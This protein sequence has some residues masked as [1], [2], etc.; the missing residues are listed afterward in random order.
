MVSSTSRWLSRAV[1]AFVF[2]GAAALALGA[3]GGDGDVTCDAVSINGDCEAKCDPAKCADPTTMTCVNNTCAQHCDAAAQHYDCPAGKLCY[4]AKGPDGVDGTYCLDAFGEGK[5]GRYEPC[6]S[7]EQ[8][9]VLRSYSCLQ[10]ECKKINCTSNFDCKGIGICVTNSAPPPAPATYCEKGITPKQPFEACA[11]T[12]ECDTDLGLACVD[13]ACR[14]VGCKTHTDCQGVGLCSEGTDDTG[15]K[16]LACTDGPVAPPGQFGAKCPGDK[17]PTACTSDTACA[18]VKVIIDGVEKEVQ[19]GCHPTIKRCMPRPDETGACPAFAPVPNTNTNLCTECDEPGGFTCIGSGPGDVDAYCGKGGCQND[20]EC[21]PGFGCQTLRTSKQPCGAA[22]GLA[23]GSATGCIAATDI[24]AGKEYS[25]GPLGL[26]RNLCVK[27]E[28]CSECT[29]DDD[30]RAVPNQI[31]AKDEGGKKIC[32]IVCDLDVS[33]ACPWGNAGGCAITDTDKNVPTCSHRFGSCAGQG[34]SCHPCVDDLD[35]PN[36]LCITSTFTNEH[37]CVSLDQ[38]CDCTN[39]PVEQGV[40]CQGGGCP[41]TPDGLTMNCY[42][43]SQ[44]QAGGSPLYQTCVGAN[45]N[46]NPL[47]SPQ[48]GCWLP[49]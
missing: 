17:T 30:C 41:Q 21:G 28:F 6:T 26:L 47:M 43:G 42:G 34:D 33:N 23:G 13:S 7:D 45:V 16:V 44:V 36:G 48:A 3:C 46:T 27:R 4:V 20:S 22:C 18:P 35:C 10:G 29:T 49:E 25:C 32:T 2:I 39:L 12:A 14:Y 38:K 31:C 37:Y 40:Q 11:T 5:T 8:C 1:R 19:Q 15:K 9:D 24:G